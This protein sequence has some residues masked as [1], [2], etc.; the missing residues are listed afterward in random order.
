MLAGQSWRALMKT[1][2]GREAL[3]L[4]RF[5]YCGVRDVSWRQCKKLEEC[6][7]QVVYGGDLWMANS[8]SSLAKQWT[9]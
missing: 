9:G 5:V 2:P 3:P 4:Q 7:A 6:Q 8:R 1:I